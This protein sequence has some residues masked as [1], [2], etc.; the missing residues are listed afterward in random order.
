MKNTRFLINYFYIYGATFKSRFKSQHIWR[1]IFIYIY[2]YLNEIHEEYH[3]YIQQIE[4]DI[5]KVE[6]VLNALIHGSKLSMKRMSNLRLESSY[7]NEQVTFHKDIVEKKETENKM[8][9]CENEHL[10]MENKN[11]DVCIRF[12]ED[13]IGKFAIVWEE[14]KHS[15]DENAN[16]LCDLRAFKTQKQQIKMGEAEV[17]K[18]Q[19]NLKKNVLFLFCDYTIKLQNC[20]KITF[21]IFFCKKITYTIKLQTAR[22][23]Q[24]RNSTIE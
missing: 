11:Y 17:A 19:E 6:V 21:L 1:H 23:S 5:N 8:L 14:L 18:L 20:K 4:N 13:A 7:L 15:A 9:V 2:I 24:N 3:I 16:E 22:K 12:C 10:N